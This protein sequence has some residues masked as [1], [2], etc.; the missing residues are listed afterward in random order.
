MSRVRLVA[1]GIIV[2]VVVVG[3]GAAGVAAWPLAQEP[4][5]WRSSRRRPRA[6]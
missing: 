1:G 3:S 4:M 5:S 6:S 2:A